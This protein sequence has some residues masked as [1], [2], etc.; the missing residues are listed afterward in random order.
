MS[1][2]IEARV[3]IPPEATSL[4][5][6]VRSHDRPGT[7]IGCAIRIDGK[8]VFSET[9][10]T[11]GEW[12]TVRVP[13]KEFA[14]CEVGLRVDAFANGWN[15]EFLF[16]D[17]IDFAGHL[18]TADTGRISL[19][20][21]QFG[22]YL[23]HVGRSGRRLGAVGFGLG[24]FEKRGIGY[25]KTGVGL[26]C[27]NNTK[28][29]RIVESGPARCVVEV[30][31][32]RTESEETKRS[33]EAVCRFVA[34]KGEPWFDVSLLS[35]KNTDKTPYALRGYDFRLQ[36]G[37][38]KAAPAGF[39]DCA[40]VVFV[41]EFLG[42]MVSQAG[43]FCLSMRSSGQGDFVRRLQGDLRPSASLSGLSEPSLRIF[44][45][46]PGTGKALFTGA[47]RISNEKGA[48]QS[49]APMSYHEE[50]G[51]ARK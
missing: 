29:I 28:S 33:F 34:C 30:T 50:K 47:W 12:R 49:T 9:L 31:A 43:D 5:F 24:E 20:F 23:V 10:K 13:V 3:K 48:P 51:E 17:T 4:R 22:P 2:G 45:G 21:E 40:G 1:S 27:A 42:A 41:K 7:D 14:G 39:P 44:V 36:P 18:F 46:E 19:T 25:K 8:E 37:S 11:E 35:L 38:G 15:F 26:A 6:V 16:I 32:E